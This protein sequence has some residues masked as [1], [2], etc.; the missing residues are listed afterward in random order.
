MEQD[1]FRALL[2][3]TVA[4]PVIALTILATVLLW[5]IQSLNSSMQWVNHT[6]QVIEAS[7]Q[8][9][10]LMI[11]V[12][13]GVRGYLSSGS[14]EFL[15]PYDEAQSVIDP[16]FAA[17][18]QLVADK[19]SQQARLATLRS[20]FDEWQSYQAARIALRRS[21]GARLEPSLQGRQLMDS[22]RAEHGAF[23]DT[24]ER[25]RAERV[26]TAQHA[27]RLLT[28][29]CILLTLG[30]GGF[31]A[32]L[33][34][35]QMHRLAADFQNSLDLAERRAEAL[36]ESERQFRTLANAIPQLCWM[37]NP[38]G[39][40]FW[41][42]QRWYEYTGTTP[43][44]MEGW[45]W[46]SVHHPETLPNVMARWQASV[47]SGEPFDMVFPLRGADGVFRP[48]LTRVMPVRDGEGK[49]VRWFGTNTDISAQMKAEQ[50]RARLAAIVD[51][52]G[53]A[54]IS[55]NL[56]GIVSSWNQSAER[57]FGYSAEEIIGQSID[58]IIPPDRDGEE[59]AFLERLRRGA[60]VDH[61]ETVRMDKGGRR[62]DVSVTLSPIRDASGAVIGISKSVRDITERKQ[63]EIELRA[64]EQR[65]RLATDAAQLGIFEWTVPTDTAV[66]EN[67]R[68]YE[69]FGIPETT[70][71]VNRDRF[72]RETLH[73]EDLPRFEPGVGRKHA[74]RRPVPGGLSHPPCE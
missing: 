23:I 45:A 13:S 66:W 17:L 8:L 62:I 10:K 30:I 69:I 64:R 38:D 47:A 56:E 3:R 2:R 53:D 22:V 73:P 59:A 58:L 51:S 55:K 31:L 71:P 11:D 27:A 37:A 18:N 16:K 67:K 25:L 44:Q 50:A 26:R 65:L 33:T 52:S 70:D 4:I 39:W 14:D 6:G 32:I 68:M 15:L 49:V 63:A 19:P 61:Y 74:A 35:R 1:S 72:V 36:R 43:E 5:E 28:V 12:D 46:Q 42:N 21:T 48:F 9:M 41:Y 57:L 60:G 54:I 40:I 7:Q 29:T 34:R 24:E 20:R